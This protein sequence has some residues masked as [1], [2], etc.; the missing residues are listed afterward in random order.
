[1]SKFNKKYTMLSILTLISI[2]AYSQLYMCKQCPNGTY[3]DNGQCSTC[4]AGSYCKEGIKYECS[5][6][7]TSIAGAS[8]CGICLKNN[9]T[10]LEV[11]VPSGCCAGTNGKSYS[12]SCVCSGC[13][14]SC[15]VGSTTFTDRV[16]PAGTKV[17]DTVYEGTFTPS[18]AS[19]SISSD[20]CSGT[21]A[22]SHGTF[23]NCTKYSPSY[24]GTIYT[25]IKFRYNS[26]KEKIEVITNTNSVIAEL[27]AKM[28]E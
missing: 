9:Y 6:G 1:M 4:P 13:T 23:F 17:D 7:G 2:P 8:S 19:T 26:S 20:S 14:S 24:K 15:S 16:F 22:Q 25:R 10:I 18:R 5:N 11:H 21:T 28:C 12:G 27:E 3:A